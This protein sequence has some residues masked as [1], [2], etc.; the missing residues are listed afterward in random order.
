MQGLTSRLRT[1]LKLYGKG[2]PFIN[3]LGEDDFKEG[4]IKIVY[5][6]VVPTGGVNTSTQADST[7]AVTTYKI[8]I[9]S[10]S[11]DQLSDDMYFVYKNQRYDIEYFNP[12]YKFQDSI[13]I[14]T[15][16]TGGVYNEWF[17]FWF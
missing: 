2:I 13:Q 9:R 14:I 8:T 3:D 15:K 12:N 17:W 16:L 1:K 7:Q 6:E 4:F 5:G 11:I 10:K